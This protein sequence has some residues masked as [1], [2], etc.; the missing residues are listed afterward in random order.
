MQGLGG[1]QAEPQILCAPFGDALAPRFLWGGQAARGMLAILGIALIPMGDRRGWFRR[2]EIEI[3]DAGGETAIC[4]RQP[5][6]RGFARSI[7]DGW[8]MG[9]PNAPSRQS[10][11]KTWVSLLLLDGFL[12]A[13]FCDFSYQPQ[14]LIHGRII[15]KHARHIGLKAYQIRALSISCGI[16]PS[17]A[18]SEIVFV[19]H[20]RFHGKSLFSKVFRSLAVACLALI[21]LILSPR[22]QWTTTK[23]LPDANI[24]IVT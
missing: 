16:F 8:L 11:Q 5:G 9:G 17:H 6:W 10:R 21:T 18:F 15:R 14:C 12:C 4:F 2:Q 20:F 19:Q 13:K 1:Q 24:P 7:N 3:S 22:S 23:T